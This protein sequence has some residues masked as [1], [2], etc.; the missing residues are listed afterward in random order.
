[1]TADAQRPST[2]SAGK[3]VFLALG[4]VVGSCSGAAV[5]WVVQTRARN[6]YEARLAAQGEEPQPAS[7]LAKP[8]S[9]GEDVFGDVQRAYGRAGIERGWSSVRPDALSSQETATGLAQYEDSVRKL[10]EKIGRD[11]AER[12]AK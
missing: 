7:R 4:L 10:P 3:L 6:A 12:H 5:A 9:A 11:L 8:G 2:P 1:M